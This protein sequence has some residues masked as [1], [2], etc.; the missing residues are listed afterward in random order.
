MDTRNSVTAPRPVFRNDYQP[1]AFLLSQVELRFEL[2]IPETRVTSRLG[3]RRNPEV[4]GTQ[5]LIL[6]GEQLKLVEIRLDGLPLEPGQYQVTDEALILHQVPAAFEL[7]ITTALNPE[8][9][10][11][12]S[13]LYRSSGKFCTQCEAEGFRRITYFPDRPDV[14]APY[15]TTLIADPKEC[16]VLLSNGN[17]AGEGVLDDG[18]HWRKWV[19][20]HPKPSYLFALVGGDLG[21]VED[22]FT[23]GGGRRVQLFIYVEHHNLDKCA[24]AMQALKNAMRWD[25]QVFGREYDL[26]R[27]MIV[28]VDDFNMGAME[29]KGLNIFNSK[30]VLAS[31]ELATDT[32]FQ[33]IEGIIG[34]EY[35]HNWSGNRVTCRDWFQLSLKEGFTVFRDQEFSADMGSRG[36][37]RIQDVN[38]LRS[39]QFREDNGPL[40]HPVQPDKYVEINNF[41]TATVYNKGA[42]LVRML[43]TLLGEQDFRRGSDLYFDRYDGQAVTIEAFISSMEEVSGRSFRQFRRW[44]HQSGTPIVEAVRDSDPA[45]GTW[46]LTLR[47]TCPPTPDQKDKSVLPIPFALALLDPESG[48]ALPLEKSAQSLSGN[49]T[50][51]LQLCKPEQSWTFHNLAKEPV[52]SLL[53]GFTAPVRMRFDYQDDELAFL[54]AH[55]SDPFARWEAGQILYRRIIFSSIADL[56]QQKPPSVPQ[57]VVSAVTALLAEDNDDPAFI[58]ECLK[59][60]AENYL[61]EFMQPY[62]PGLL[63]QA[64]RSLQQALSHELGELFLQV[65]LCNRQTGYQLDAQAMGQRALRNRCLHY[66]LAA[67]TTDGHA[68]ALKQFRQSGNMTDRLSALDALINSSCEA[69]GDCLEEFFQAWQHEPLVIDKWFALQARADRTDTL[70]RVQSL[71]GHPLFS[72]KN[73]N[74]VY[75]LLRTFS[76]ANPAHF[77]GRTGAGYRL[78]VEQLK[79]LDPVNPQVAARLA[80]A[81]TLLPELEPGRQQSMRQA[82]E[83]INLNSG[84][85]KDLYEI[86]NKILN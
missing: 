42:E 51:L 40:A 56:Q 57:T 48:K 2:A 44:Y 54:L 75:A 7:V 13:G 12:L 34:H 5:P 10:T 45:A 32:D 78:L 37:Q 81:F 19:D 74:R 58:A 8:E 24:H 4:A 20:P 77:H 66:V 62:D 35:F 85:S 68:L 82:L 3:M 52:P 11:E 14:L 50:Q 23:T 27:Y 76:T 63:H 29:N 71:L 83:S 28:A 43:R 21:W 15:T 72:L 60:P 69:A 80:T 36:V 17:P 1:P 46:T 16:P 38:L 22:H 67:D 64:R 84:I 73:P 39:H 47:Q 79:R 18:R 9:N 86:I 55:D 53:R 33:Q 31:P 25:E 65:Y 26:A 41:Y 59:L 30:Y 6:N 61:A 70:Q 49:S